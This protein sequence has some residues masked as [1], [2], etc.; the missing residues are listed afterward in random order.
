M[1]VLHLPGYTEHEKMKI[2]QKYLIPKEIKANALKL[3]EIVIEEEAL[4]GIIKDY[5]REAG[6]RNVEREIANVCRKA[7]KAVAEGK[8]TPIVIKA[9]D[10]HDYL[11]NPKYFAETAIMI[12]RPGVV[13]GLAWTPSGGDILFVEATQ[14]PGNKQLTLT[15]QLGDVM[16]ESAQA[17]LSYVRSQ[18]EAFGINKDFFEKTDIHIHVPAGAIPKDGPS[19]GV[20]MTTAIVSMLTGRLAKHDLAMTGEITL[21]GKVMPIGGVKEKVLAAKR[22]GIRTVILPEKNKNDLD[23]VPEDL[24]KEMEFIFVDTIDQVIKHALNEKKSA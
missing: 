20:T 4:L 18:T 9:G 14:M 19:A 8:P 5:T 17:A 12:D 6:V 7:A 23:D 21:R 16:K 24:R 15:G 13:T 1:E 2:A 3:E 22:A 10:L 11:G